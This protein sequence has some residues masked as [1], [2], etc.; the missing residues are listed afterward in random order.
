MVLTII[1]AAGQCLA[2][3]ADTSQP[4]LTP[5]KY[6]LPRDLTGNLYAMG[7]E[8]KKLLFRFKRVATRADN[9]LDVRR[10][11]S[12]SEGKPVAREHLVYQGDDLVFFE[13]EELQIGAKGSAKI[14]RKA[15]G[16]HLGT[17][18]FEYTKGVSI[19]RP[20][21]TNE[22]LQPNTLTADMVGPFL[23]S[24]CDELVRG[25]KIKCRYLV[26]P[27]L[28][29][30][31]FTF[32]K[33]SDSTYNGRPI[34]VVKMEAS[35]ALIRTQVDPLY[36]KIEKALPHRALEYSGRTTPKIRN[37]GHWKDLDALT[38]FDW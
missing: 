6:E 34:I 9:T 13:L 11:F 35:H 12:D 14:H 15:G 7:P 36:F 33:D 25:E 17:I 28:E 5:S 16:N 24:H 30:V 3:C 19:A 8:P 1:L 26:V 38:V 4:Q 37:G 22:P 32:S 29:T 31:G 18:D 23:Q 20:A 21:H 27:R 2:L 10:E